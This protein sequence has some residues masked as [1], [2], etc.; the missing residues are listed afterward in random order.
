MTFNAW[1]KIQDGRDDPVGDFSRDCARAKGKPR[2][3]IIRDRWVLYLN[4]MNACD[5]AI[6]AFMRAWQEWQD[7]EQTTRH[8]TG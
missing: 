4:S 5:G 7:Y 8:S 3:C 6:K 1:L 2:G